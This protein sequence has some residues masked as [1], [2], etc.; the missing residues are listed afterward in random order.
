MNDFLL[1][2]DTEAS[3]LP[4]KW[5]LPYGV[6]GN[7]P[8]AVQI[9]WIIYTGE[10]EIVK[11]ENHYISDNDFNIS[12]RA[13]R[14]HGLSQR[15]LTR[16]GSRR[17]IVMQKLADDLTVYQPLIAGHFMELDL[18]IINAE[19]YRT[20]LPNPAAALPRFCTMLAT[21]HLVRHPARKY[22][23]LRDLY[24]ALF[25]TPL[26]KEHDALADS[27]ATASCFFELLRLGEIDTE[28]IQQ[29]KEVNHPDEPA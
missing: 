5:D 18:H 26:K 4:E 3:G 13:K 9:A 8:Y 11:E 6:P 7:W 29:Q 12:F 20:G 14:V 28:K 22:L 1:F 23:R 21:T 24:Y 25:N 2:I 10:G 19:F 16:N 17:N 27:K 15:F